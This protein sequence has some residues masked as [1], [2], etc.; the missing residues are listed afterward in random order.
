MKQ[1]TPFLF[2]GT[3]KATIYK[4]KVVFL[5]LRMPNLAA[6]Q[7]KVVYYVQNIT[8]LINAKDFAICLTTSRLPDRLKFVTDK[9]LCFACLNSGHCASSCSRTDC[10]RRENC[11]KKHTTLLHPPPPPLRAEEDSALLGPASSRFV[12]TPTNKA[13]GVC[14]SRFVP[15]MASLL[16]R[17]PFWVALH[18]SVPTSCLKG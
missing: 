1:L 18:L 10:C 2:I 4:P 3:S 9:N 16:K 15:I 7:P 17:M 5:H 6:T 14:L 13:T 8:I 12:G 11:H